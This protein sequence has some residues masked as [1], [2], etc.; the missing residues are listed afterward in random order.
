MKEIANSRWMQCVVDTEK[1][2]LTLTSFDKKK[3]SSSLRFV[4]PEP[5]RLDLT[6]SFEGKAVE[7]K[8][9]RIPESRFPLLSRGFHWIN[10]YPFSR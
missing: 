6:G 5:A 8:L 4:Q 2:T 1:S 7:A 9:R 3:S 10:E